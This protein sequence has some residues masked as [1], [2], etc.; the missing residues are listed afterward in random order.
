VPDVV[1]D[2]QSAG[3]EDRAPRL[4]ERADGLGGLVRVDEDGVHRTG[5]V[6][7]IRARGLLEREPP[8]SLV[9]DER[10]VAVAPRPDRRVEREHLA[11]RLGQREGDRRPR[12]RRPDLDDTSTA[13]DEREQRRD[14]S[15]RRA[16]V[17]RAPVA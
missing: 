6:G 12:A 14:V 9:R 16:R 2:D 7:R 13:G 10:D 11:L 5:Y 15:R 3:A 1:E 4:E 8:P 17:E